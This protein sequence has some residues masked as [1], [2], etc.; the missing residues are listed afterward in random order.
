MLISEIE[1]Q[2]SKKMN[3]T[4]NF[5]TNL[6]SFADFSDIT[7]SESF[8]PIPEDWKVIITDVKGATE[9][10][11]AGRYKDVNLIGAASIV[12]AQNAMEGEDFPFVFGGD[13]ASLIIPPQKIELVKKELCRLRKHSKE[14]FGL[15]LR[16]G[17]VE[18][19]QLYSEGS[20]I[21]VAKHELTHGKCIAVFRGGGLKEAEQKVKNQPKT[22]ELAENDSGKVNLKGLSCRW[23]AF[24][25]RRG[26]ILSILVA[27]SPRSPSDTYKKVIKYLDEIYDGDFQIA[28]PLDTNS[29]KY[30]SFRECL[31][32]EKRYHKSLI[33][34][35]F[36]IKYLEIIL[37]V[38]IF[39][40]KIPPFF[41]NSKRYVKSMKTHSDFRKFDDML[42]LVIDCSSEQADLI[43]GYL[44]KMYENG[45]I[46]YG[47]YESNTS[48]VTCFV[49][50]VHD[51]GHIHFVDGGDGGYAMAAKQLKAQMK[52]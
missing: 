51:G 12:A 7:N 31:K 39:K 29:L 27:A 17:M 50:T 49:D 38:L 24:P 19:K 42:R 47:I 22:Y 21:E 4:N 33:S 37:A 40:F 48:L 1:I 23:N 36:I 46:F 9:A 3:K 52:I 28:N 2:S 44:D 11:E 35:S 15:Q 13:G 26:K 5:Y 10:I 34:A 41:F 18:V 25:T 16:V 30:K 6:R 14:K 43:R 8:E 45:E 32:E 20:R